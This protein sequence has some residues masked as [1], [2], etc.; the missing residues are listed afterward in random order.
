MEAVS[1]IKELAAVYKYSLQHGK[2]INAGVRVWF[3]HL[4]FVSC[5]DPEEVTV[6]SL[7]KT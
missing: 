7:S 5:Y 6:Q 1:K 2:L 3:R 4:S